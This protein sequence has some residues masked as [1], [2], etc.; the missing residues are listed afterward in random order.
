LVKNE[1]EKNDLSKW[2]KQTS[3]PSKHTTYVEIQRTVTPDAT[4][5]PEVEVLQPVTVA[6]VIRMSK[7]VSFVTTLRSHFVQAKNGIEP[8]PGSRHQERGGRVKA[9]LRQARVH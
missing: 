8:H 2:K 4:T 9:A 3:D 1:D 5:K 6:D 7:F